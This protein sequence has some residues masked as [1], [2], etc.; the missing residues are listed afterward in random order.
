MAALNI[1]GAASSSVKPG[2]LSKLKKSVGIGGVITGGL[3]L[4]DFA[5]VPGAFSLDYNNKGE[6]VEGTNWKSGFKEL[7]KSA[8]KCAGYLAIPLAITSL[9]AGGGVLLAAAAGIASFASSFALSSIFEKALPKEEELMAEACKKK[10][11]DLTKPQT[12]EFTA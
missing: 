4:L 2:T 10:G 3:C 5:S 12:Q 9:A 1:L 7:G 8:L 6:K 11:I